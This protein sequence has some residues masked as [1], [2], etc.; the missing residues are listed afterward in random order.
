MKSAR[1][2]RVE[3]LAR[4]LWTN[5]NYHDHEAE[6]MFVPTP[7][8]TDLP[9]TEAGA[10]RHCGPEAKEL[11]FILHVFLRSSHPSLVYPPQSSCFAAHLREKRWS[12]LESVD[13]ARPCCNLLSFG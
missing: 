4:R 7:Q 2:S 3:M 11:G 10:E 9:V 1:M 5:A 13:E 8:P 6:P 12:R